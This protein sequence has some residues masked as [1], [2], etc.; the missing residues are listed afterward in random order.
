[1]SDTHEML[2]CPACNKDMKKVFVA[3]EGVNIDICLDGCGG[4][5]FDNR[6]IKY[7]DE[8]NEKIDEIIAVIDGKEFAKV[9][10]TNFRSCP[11]CGARMVKNF[12]SVKQDIKIDECYACGG[13]FL[14]NSELQAMRAEYVTEADR[15]A[16]M[17]SYM[18]A[19]VGADIKKLDAEA[20]ELA[21]HRS[22]LK[23][24]FDKMVLG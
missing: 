5:W 18:Y 9:D 14:D 23:K 13:K 17:V 22:W 1:M 19:T 4:M 16:D 8:Q 11:V 10:Q 12:S 20:A 24:L 6:E 15:S 3:K 7:F 21:S 2:K